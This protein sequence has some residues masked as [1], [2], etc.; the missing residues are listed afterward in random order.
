MNTVQ[1]DTA[2]FKEK[3]FDYTT[4]KDWQYDGPLPAIIDFYADWCK[5]CKMMK[6]YLDEISEEMKDKV[7][8]YRI[9]ADD[10][11]ELCK[12]LAVEAL[13]TIFIYKAQK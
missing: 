11:P 8:V 3:I 13:P 1:L 9:N 6:P 4:D 12:D 2:G 10:N 5:P 7:V